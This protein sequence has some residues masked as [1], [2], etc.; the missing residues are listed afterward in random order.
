MSSHAFADF[1]EQLQTDRRLVRHGRVVERRGE[2]DALAQSAAPNAVLFPEVEQTSMPL[3]V[4]VFSA[5]ANVLKAFGASSFGEAAGRILE[6]LAQ[7]S[8]ETW[9]ERLGVNRL[10]PLRKYQP[11]TVRTATA[12]QIVRLGRDVD[13]AG[14]PAPVFSGED[15]PSLN[16]GRLISRGPGDDRLHVGRY[17]FRVLGPNRLVA[18]WRPSSV[19]ARLLAHYRRRGETM[20]VAIAFGG[21]PLDLLLAMAP[22]P[23]GADVFELTGC[24]RGQPCEVV[25]GRHAGLPVPA[26]AELVI[27]GFI[28]PAEPPADPG[29]GLDAMGLV[30]RLRPGPVLRV[31]AITHRPTPLFPW[32][33]PGEKAEIQRALGRVFLPLLR[34]QLP[35]LC[36]LDFPAFGGDRV[37]A[38]ASIDQTYA[39]EA[40]QFA[41]AFWAAAEMLPVRYLVVVDADVDVHEADKV[42]AAVAA[43][44]APAS[45][46]HFAES[47]PDEFLR[48]PAP[49][50]MVI[51]AT[52]PPE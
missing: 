9:L 21:Q 8:G 51:D 47:P 17:D 23:A 39:G 31:E 14:L 29:S 33:L 16:A 41:Q 25:A 45:D 30:G 52:G 19:A 36:D 4:G 50:R 37:W 11:R 22:L 42:W 26:D 32:L 48:D 46:V 35:G 27:E 10:S 2:I 6:I 18:C 38:L 1:L 12:Q 5:P 28:D 3:V 20:P 13:L 44:A 49:G 7:G 15:L 43:H 40:G 34:P 24:L